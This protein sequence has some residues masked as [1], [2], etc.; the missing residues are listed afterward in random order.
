MEGIETSALTDVQLKAVQDDLGITAAMNAASAANNNAEAAMEEASKGV[1]DAAAAQATADK[2]VPV[3][4]VTAGNMFPATSNAVNTAL[5]KNVNR[6][7]NSEGTAPTNNNA[8]HTIIAGMYVCN[9]DI[10]GLPVATYGVLSVYGQYTEVPSGARQWIYQDFHTIS[11][12]IYHRCS[13]N[14]GSLTPDNWTP[15]EKYVKDVQW[16]DCSLNSGVS[17]STNGF[18]GYEKPQYKKVGNRVYIRGGVK[19]TIGESWAVLL[20]FRVPEGYR[21]PNNH[22]YLAALGGKNIA[23]C[24]MTA[25]GN[26]YIE[27]LLDLSNGEQLLNQT[28]QWLDISCDYEV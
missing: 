12:D 17:P 14:G 1:A 6:I 26:F 10:S 21:P 8:D 25:A 20:C 4:E 9:P 19:F 28:V 23:R 15:W 5:I 22:Y 7:I 27:W 11:G 3:D 2:G 24:Y 16:I 13:I 18:G